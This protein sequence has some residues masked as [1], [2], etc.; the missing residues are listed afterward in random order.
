M[1]HIMA[2][3]EGKNVVLD[4][5]LIEEV[6]D[7]INTLEPYASRDLEKTLSMLSKDIR[8]KSTLNKFGVIIQ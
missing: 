6:E 7:F 4:Q 1:P 2:L 5:E 3:T 8:D